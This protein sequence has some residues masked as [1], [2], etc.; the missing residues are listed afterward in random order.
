MAA[1]LARGPLAVD[2]SLAGVTVALVDVPIEAAYERAFVPT[3]FTLRSSAGTCRGG[4]A[5]L[6]I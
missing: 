6:F 4:D 5:G 2:A 1:S 3:E